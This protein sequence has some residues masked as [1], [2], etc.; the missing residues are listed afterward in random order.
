[1]L[2]NY[3][4]RSEVFVHRWQSRWAC[5]RLTRSRGFDTWFGQ[6]I[7]FFFLQETNNG[8]IETND[9]DDGVK[10]NLNSTCSF[11]ELNAVL[12]PYRWQDV[13]TKLLSELIPTVHH[14]VLYYDMIRKKFEISQI[15]WIWIFEKYS[16]ERAVQGWWGRQAG[17]S[18]GPVGG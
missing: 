18:A 10:S 1:M 5:G 11:R 17:L 15:F 7:I 3:G 2:Q 6:N 13:P 12:L 14:D 16:V 9:D 8:K 4:D